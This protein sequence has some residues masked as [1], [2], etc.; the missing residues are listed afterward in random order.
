MNKKKDALCES[1][2]VKPLERRATVIGDS[3]H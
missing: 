1:R 2:F 3:K